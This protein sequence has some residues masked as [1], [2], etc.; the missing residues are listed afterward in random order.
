MVRMDG[1]GKIVWA[2]NNEIQ[3]KLPRS[4]EIGDEG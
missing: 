1:T 2:K 4:R 3:F